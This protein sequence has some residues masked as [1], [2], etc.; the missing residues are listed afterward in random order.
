MV[1]VPWALVY[2]SDLWEWPILSYCFLDV[3]GIILMA[4]GVFFFVYCTG[5]FAYFGRGTPAPIEPPQALVVKGIY[6]YSRNPM[7]L[8]YF[9]I[10]MGEFLVFGRI[11]LLVYWIFILCLITVY[12]VRWE[13]PKL[14]ERFGQEYEDYVRQ[15]PRWFRIV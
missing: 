12:V 11:L 1:A 14:R 4:A 15:V 6:H 5:L 9:A 7:Y 8:G 3:I 13:E 10:L 2:L